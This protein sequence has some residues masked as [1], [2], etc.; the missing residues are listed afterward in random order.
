VVGAYTLHAAAPQP[1][2]AS[3]LFAAAAASAF[4]AVQRLARHPPGA[5]DAD[6]TMTLNAHTTACVAAEPRQYPQSQFNS[7]IC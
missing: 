1:I 3:T 5:P 6:T 7:I 4:K 2:F